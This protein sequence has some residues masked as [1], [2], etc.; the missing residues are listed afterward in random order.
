[1]AL[2]AEQIMLAVDFIKAAKR[3]LAV[4][5]DEAFLTVDQTRGGAFFFQAVGERAAV[6]Q[7][8]GI[9][10]FRDGGSSGRPGSSA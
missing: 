9:L 4:A 5:Q 1:M 2:A 6:P 7:Q 8:L 3:Q 10:V